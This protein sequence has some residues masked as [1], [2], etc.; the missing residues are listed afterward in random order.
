M[1]RDRHAHGGQGMHWIRA[2]KRL[3]IYLR[4]GLAC[5]WCGEGIEDGMRLTLD[6]LTPHSRGGANGAQNLVTYCHRCNSSR[7]A[8]SMRAFAGVVAGYL[9]HG[10]QAETILAHV[11]TT[12]RRAIDV[13]AAVAL[14]ARR[15]GF[16][17]A[18]RIK[19]RRTA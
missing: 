1:P 2:E 17:A 4:D 14:I 19:H 6:H 18:C 13:P 3:A 11:R 5:A 15:G 9:D 16:V 12:C 7:G 8:R 10:A